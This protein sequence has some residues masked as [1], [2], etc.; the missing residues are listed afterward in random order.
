ML[1]PAHAAAAQL[2]AITLERAQYYLEVHLQFDTRPAYS[3]SM[4]FDPDRYLLTFNGCGLAVPA[5][6]LKAL[7]EIDNHLLTR[8]SSY[9]ANSNLQLGFYLNQE[10]RPLIRYDDTGYYLRF[11]TAARLERVTALAAGLSLT[12]KQVSYQ[13]ENFRLYLVRVDPGAARVFAA[14][15]DRYDGKTRRRAPSSFGRREQADVVV[16][17]GFFGANGEHL[18][19]FV[20]DGVIRATGVYPTR[21]MLVVTGAGEIRIGRFNVETALITGGTKIPLSGKNYPFENGKVLAYSSGYP[22]DK[23]PQNGM[24]YYLLENGA[25]RYY[26]A[27]TSGLW[28]A[29]DVTLIA[30]DIIPEANPLRGLADGTPAVLETRITDAAG[31]Q[32]NA[33]SV[34][35]GAPMLVEEG[36]IAISNAQDKV[37][38]DIAKSERSRTAAG[39]TRNGQLLLAVVKEQESGGFGGVTLDALATI[40]INEGAW[41]AL[42]F[43]GGGSSAIVAA[44]QLLNLAE[45]AERTV[46]NVL[47]VKA[48]A[49][50]E[51]QP[52][53]AILSMPAD[54]P[55]ASTPVTSTD[56]R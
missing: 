31:N 16:N 23:L 45:S 22:I 27:S 34:I 28:L 41:T 5:D 4:R 36:K 30:T 26:S 1:P 48:G 32:I 17:G 46:S 42:N 47:I 29:P 40:L 50:A 37:R 55:P 11:Y 35:G 8:I 25:L 43:D 9:S 38:A 54:P 20:E 53:A 21:P 24:Y 2:K 18:S 52:A 19:T 14:G 51:Q 39:L 12:E 6:Q 44:G 10:L 33:A 13:G 15:A 7:D 56:V 49:P 3:E